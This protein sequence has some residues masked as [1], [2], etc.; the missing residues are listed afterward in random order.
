MKKHSFRLVE[1]PRRIWQSLVRTTRRSHDPFLV[2][3]MVSFNYGGGWSR[4]LLKASLRT[5]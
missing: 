3:S 2:Y 5:T 4:L 1:W